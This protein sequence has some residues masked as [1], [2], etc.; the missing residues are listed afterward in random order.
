[1][2]HKES[3]INMK[4]WKKKKNYKESDMLLHKNMEKKNSII[5]Y[6]FYIYDIIA[7]ISSFY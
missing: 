6:M 1:M 7:L 4:T 3:G 5:F 2:V